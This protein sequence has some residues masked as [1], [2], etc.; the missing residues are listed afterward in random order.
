MSYISR[1]SRKIGDKTNPL[2][3]KSRRRELSRTDFTIFSNNCWAGSVYRRYGLPYGSPTAGLYFF[4]DD[5]VKFASRLMHYTSVPLEFID[6]RDSRH[7]VQLREK[8]ELEK[9][10]AILDDIEIVFLHYSSRK[11]AE[12]KW[13]R[14]CERINWGDV[15]IKF[16]QMN[17]C[18]EK[19]LKAF[20]AIPFHNKLCFTSTPRPDLECA[21]YYPGFGKQEGI[22]NDTDYYSRYVNLE[23]WLCCEPERYELG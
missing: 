16:S 17:C 19:E 20:D 11:E 4:A 6:S 9:P 21:V 10:I 3:A 18:T 1:V 7:V 13:T 2:F 22:L 12:E 14:R 15:F 8:G 23:E 5:Y